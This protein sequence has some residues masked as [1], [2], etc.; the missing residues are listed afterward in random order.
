MAVAQHGIRDDR[1]DTCDHSSALNLF[2]IMKLQARTVLHSLPPPRPEI[3]CSWQR[4][5]VGILT[6]SEAR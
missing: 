4:L 1:K 2:L 6:S 5:A 3:G